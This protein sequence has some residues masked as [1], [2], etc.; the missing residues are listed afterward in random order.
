[1]CLGPVEFGWYSERMVFILLHVATIARVWNPQVLVQ[2][3]AETI[4]GYCW[5]VITSC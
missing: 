3:K 1:M 5:N 4:I 2:S